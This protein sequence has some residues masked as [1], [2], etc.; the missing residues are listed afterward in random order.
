MILVGLTGGIGAG[1]STVSAMLAEY[2][3]VVIDADQIAR[4][5]QN[6][7]SP[8]LAQMADR[9]GSQILR[10][11]GSL[12]RAAVAT[13]VFGDS[14]QAKQALADLNGIT[15]PA[16]L[17]EI[18]RQISEQADTDN[19]VVLDFPLLGENPRD[20]M[21]ATIV[22]DVPVAVA[23][24][25]LV[26]FRGMTDTDARN[27][28]ASQISPADRLAR[29]THIV[30]NSGDLETLRAEV[31]ALWAAINELAEQPN[32]PESNRQQS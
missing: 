14:D 28:I 8:L 31:D 26:E 1:K 12:E 2:G 22:V 6:P 25:R 23:V 3:A 9:F 7:G 13:I 27:R 30:D 4:D 15:H 5:L 29:A 17:D 24:Q 18:R 21:Q 20:D 32:A 10:H 11:D 16:I 19:I